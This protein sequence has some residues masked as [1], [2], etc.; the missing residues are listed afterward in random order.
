[1]IRL[2][3]RIY[4]WSEAT[5]FETFVAKNEGDGSSEAV[6]VSLFRDLGADHAD[7]VLAIV[8]KLRAARVRSSR[9][10]S[11][12]K[13]HSLMRSTACSTPLR[14]NCSKRPDDTGRRSRSHGLAGR[15]R[16]AQH[17]RNERR[18]HADADPLAYLR[19]RGNARMNAPTTLRPDVDLSDAY[20][21]LESQNSRPDAHGRTCPI[22]RDQHFSDRTLP[23]KPIPRWAR[24]NCASPAGFP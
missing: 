15:I 10:Q 6:L 23:T 7:P 3:A 22:P 5:D 14:P 8:A 16:R 21:D 13:V 4:L 18:I 11:G 17:S 2:K 19:P 12:V 24:V 9:K 1:M 20:M